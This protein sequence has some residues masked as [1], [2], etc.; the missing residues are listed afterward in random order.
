[1]QSEKISA[2]YDFLTAVLLKIKS[3]GMWKCILGQVVPWSF[4]RWYSLH[5]ESQ[6]VHN[7]PSEPQKLLTQQHFQFPEYMTQKKN[8]HNPPFIWK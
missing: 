1:M 8:F 7:D 5:L 2:T 3:S 4:K 6:K